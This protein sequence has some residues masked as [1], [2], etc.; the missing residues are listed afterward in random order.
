MPLKLSSF[1]ML[2]D[3]HAITWRYG[4]VFFF[5]FNAHKRAH[6]KLCNCLCNAEDEKKD[7]S[8]GQVISRTSLIE[9]NRL[10]CRER[11]LDVLR[12]LLCCFSMLPE[13]TIA[14]CAVWTGGLNFGNY[15]RYTDSYTTAGIDL[16]CADGILY[17]VMLTSGGSGYALRKMQNERAET[18]YYNLY[19]DA[20]YAQIW[21]DGHSG[22]GVRHGVGNG[23]RQ[24]L[25]IYGRIPA[26]QKAP[27][28]VYSDQV[29][30][31]VNF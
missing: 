31:T 11:C 1:T 4:A 17:K 28:G 25:I 29:V 2:R 27:P 12:M 21:A 19:I 3:V 16:K 10:F 26:G 8:D 6:S 24:S 18:L 7:K 14:Q 22:T 13:Q 20:G 15:Q 9:V 5:V 23:V 30:I